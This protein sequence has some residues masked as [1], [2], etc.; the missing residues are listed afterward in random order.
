MFSSKQR[1]AKRD[2]N[3]NS[4]LLNWLASVRLEKYIPVFKSNEVT[5]D[6]FVMLS[7][8]DLEKMGIPLGP[9]KQILQRIA[10]LKQ[11]QLDKS[12]PYTYKDNS[13]KPPVE[14]SRVTQ[15][16]SPKNGNGA[17]KGDLRTTR[18]GW[19][20]SVPTKTT[21]EV[22]MGKYKRHEYYLPFVS[23][24]FTLIRSPR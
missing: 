4:G 6:N 5:D 7:Q 12:E 17:S 14:Y 13:E 15:P 11:Q 24:L 9:Q 3:N 21:L 19:L 22:K 18:G 8:Y 10:E 23:H 1:T 2:Q 20:S 16:A